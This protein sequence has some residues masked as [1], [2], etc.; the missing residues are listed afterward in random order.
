M[1]PFLSAAIAWLHGPDASEVRCL[2]CGF[3]WQLAGPEAVQVIGE[4]PKRYASNLADWDDRRAVPEGTWSPVAYVWHVVDV[5]RGWSERFR[6]IAED[7]ETQLAPWDPDRLAAARGYGD[8]PLAGALWSL[9][10][11]TDDVRSAVG[12][13]DH[14]TGFT[15]PEWG[16]GDVED[17]LRWLAHEVTHHEVD[18]AR[19]VGH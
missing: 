11:A 15:H 14:R 16:R 2:E 6:A 19:G 5:L 3:A 10:R 8:L 18:I 13:L 1:T 7:P 12:D 17:A 9:E 4:A